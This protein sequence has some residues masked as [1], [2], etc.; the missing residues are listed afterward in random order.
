MKPPVPSWPVADT[1]NSLNILD[2]YV[3]IFVIV[4]KGKMLT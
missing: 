1:Y 3:S 2:I 4:G